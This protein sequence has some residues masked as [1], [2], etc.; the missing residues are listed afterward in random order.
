MKILLVNPPGSL[1]E[2]YGSEM[3]KFGAVS[4][5]M[6]LAYIA[7]FLEKKKY[8]VKI[9]DAAVLGMGLKDVEQF[10]KKDYFDIIGVTMLTPSYSAVLNTLRMIKKVSPGTVTVCGG[11][12]P[13]AF[14]G[15]TLEEIKELDVVC[16]GEGENTMYE[17]V[18]SLE[19]NKDFAKIKGIAFRQDNRIVI[20]APRPYENNLDNFPIPARHLLPVDKYSLTASRTSG[21]RYCPTIIVARGCPF[22]C[23]FCYRIFGST[24]RH[25]SIE[26]IIEELKLL[27]NQYQASQV[28]L[29]A[30][31]ISI[32]KKFLISL[33]D[34]IISSGINV[35]IKWTCESRVSTIDEDVL[36]KMKEAGCWQISYGVES[37]VQRLLDIIHKGVSLEQIE[38]IF[39]L[40]KKHKI[41]I[42]SFF[43]LGLPT[44]TREESY[45]TIEFA[46]KLDADWAQF[47]LTIPYPGTHLYSLVKDSEDLKSKNWDE[48]NTWGGWKE[49]R[50]PYVTKGR[51]E[52]ELK[53][54]QKIAFYRFYM[55]PKIFF[56]FLRKSLSSFSEFR[57]ILSGFLILLTTGRKGWSFKKHGHTR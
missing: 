31:T 48:Y 42:R 15:E 10:L 47:T 5:P 46:K 55:R 2:R 30:D 21:G 6:G 19:D 9:L 43:M 27:I 53:K 13:T 51:T 49:G 20:N 32:D 1:E 45:Q 28:N 56:R 11:P 7:S 52:E 36:K 57:K 25:H 17:I 39:K 14:P 34:A 16:I 37:G 4:E 44:E 54:F 40:T 26:R 29:E 41:S 33:C 18:R 12:H 22:K 3:K 35:K 50:L 23:A 24:F 38:R 8:F